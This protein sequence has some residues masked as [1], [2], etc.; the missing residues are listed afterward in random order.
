VKKRFLAG[1]VIFLLAFLPVSY[2][3]GKNVYERG[4]KEGKEEVPDFIKEFTYYE[5]KRCNRTEEAIYCYLFDPI[6]RKCL[7]QR[8][9]PYFGAE[10]FMKI[11]CSAMLEREKEKAEKDSPI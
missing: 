8:I 7:L 4:Y 3:T 10:S 2:Y 9:E 5:I 1:L 6:Y 11:P